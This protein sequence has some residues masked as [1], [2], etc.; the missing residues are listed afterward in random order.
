[1]KKFLGNFLFLGLSVATLTV[2]LIAQ[3]SWGQSQV[4]QNQQAEQLI[5]KGKQQVQQQQYQQAIQTFQEVLGIAR[6][7]KDQRLEADTLTRIGDAYSN[8][9]EKRKALDFYNQ[10]LRIYEAVGNKNGQATTLNNIGVITYGFREEQEA[11]LLYNQ[12]LLLYQAENNQSGEATVLNNIG[13]IYSDLGENAKASDFYNQARDLRQIVREKKQL[14]REKSDEPLPFSI[15]GAS[16]SGPI[17]GSFIIKDLNKDKIIDKSEVS[18][19]NLSFNNQEMKISCGFSD[20]TKFELDDSQDHL[21]KLTL[22]GGEVGASLLNLNINCK[23]KNA[24]I[25]LSGSELKIKTTIKNNQSR[26]TQNN[27]STEVGFNIS[28]GTSSTRTE[29]TTRILALKIKSMLEEAQAQTH[30]ALAESYAYWINAGLIIRG[31]SPR[32]LQTL[33]NWANSK[34]TIEVKNEMIRQIPISGD[35][36]SSASNDKVCEAYAYLKNIRFKLLESRSEDHSRLINTCLSMDEA[37]YRQQIDED[38]SDI[39]LWL[40]FSVHANN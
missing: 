16:S 35:Y 33:I 36:F 27:N 37:T 13:Q 30:T 40:L 31:I 32:D 10:A 7:V 26:N 11:L 23:N 20:L 5:N 12:A 38:R 29:Y 24:E 18:D 25:D 4:S 6:E 34:N 9:K 22:K 8:L 2:P 1:M 17:S 19:F 3:P 14:V 15:S 28:L 39:L 21:R